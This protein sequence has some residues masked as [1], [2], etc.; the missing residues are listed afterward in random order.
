M[1]PAPNNLD[2]S[3][4]DRQIKDTEVVREAAMVESNNRVA[5]AGSKCLLDVI[6][7]PTSRVRTN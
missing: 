4:A 3:Y 1:S 7:S 5:A 2:Q 6:I